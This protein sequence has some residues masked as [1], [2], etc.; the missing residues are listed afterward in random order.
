MLLRQTHTVA[1][2]DL[3]PA[4]YDEI[5][6]KLTA[7]KYDLSKMNIANAGESAVIDL[8]GIGIAMEDTAPGTENDKQIGGQHYGLSKFQHWDMVDL[9]KLDYFQGQITKYVMRWRD[10]NGIQDLEKGQHFLEKYIALERKK[11]KVD[12][13]LALRE[14]QY[15]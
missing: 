13:N 6:A 11:I 5:I 10:K 8:S 3:S 12:P 4:A 14:R 2:L 9:F 7:A 15:R 1:T